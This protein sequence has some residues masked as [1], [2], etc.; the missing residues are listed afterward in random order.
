MKPT[1]SGRMLACALVVLPAL[2]FSAQE[3]L[4]A[5]FAIKEQ[6]GT[7]LGNAFA[8]SA[9]G[10]D[11]ISYSYY[12]PAMMGY[13]SGNHAAVSGS[14]IMP[15]SNFKNGSA[16]TITGQPINTT[17]DFNG[18]KDIGRD[19]LVPA[20]YGMWSATE[21]L[22]L[23]I[24][25]TLPFGLLTDN[26]PGWEGR[27][28]ALKSDLKTIDINPAIA[29]RVLPNLSI[30]GGFRAVYADAELSN[31][32]DAGSICAADTSAGGCND[33]A[34]G[35]G[36]PPQPTQQDVRA[37]LDAD[38][39]GFGFNLGVMYEP[40]E[41]LRLGV[42]YRSS[43]DLTLDGDAEFDHSQSG[44]S[45]AILQAGGFLNDTDADSSVDLP[46]SVA[47][48]ATYDISDEWAVMGQ[49]EWWNWSN[50]DELRVNFDDGQPDSV[51]EENWDDSWFFALGTTYKPKQVEGLTVR[52]GLA[53]DESPVPDK[54][55]TPRVPDEDRYWIAAG[56]GYTPLPWLT[57]DLGYTHIFMPDADIDLKATDPG[58]QFR[59]DLSGEYEANIDIIA[60]QAT[61]RF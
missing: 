18:N 55:R 30:G 49:V 35:G 6:S 21:E 51:T 33:I 56:I 10:T 45:G 46:D 26:V 11:D 38:D 52:L 29:Y 48:G 32:V 58:N 1:K 59:G 50:F 7:A 27:Y 16:S 61:A 37:K 36:S 22:K 43:V 23:G 2:I 41:R 44:L 54:T 28:H 20:L 42:A 60:F 53:F 13:L 9:S 47:F 4:A 12:N 19:A 5:G 3:A 8:G 57:F 24:S 15:D 14:Y 25:V 34:T 39:W 40:I 31:S 17:N